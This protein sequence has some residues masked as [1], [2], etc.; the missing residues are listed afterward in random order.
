MPDMTL[1]EAKSIIYDWVRSPE[2]EYSGADLLTREL[3]A[4]QI[5]MMIEKVEPQLDKEL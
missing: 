4:N 5:A 1:Q 2:A 3:I